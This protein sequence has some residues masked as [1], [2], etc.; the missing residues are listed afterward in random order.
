MQMQEVR[1]FIAVCEELNFT[2]A[3][4]L[5]GVSQPSISNAIKRLEQTLGGPLF[6]RE[7]GIIQ[8]T[9]LGQ[10]VRPYLQKIDRYAREAR[11]KAAE[12]R[13]VR[14]SYPKPRHPSDAVMAEQLGE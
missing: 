8:L 6:R 14:K 10:I 11:R 2:R 3:A 1:Y 4:T 9:E 12:F 13:R 5:C 7:S